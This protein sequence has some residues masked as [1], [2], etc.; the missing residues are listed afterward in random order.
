MLDAGAEIRRASRP[1]LP[2]IILLLCG[3]VALLSGAS[4]LLWVAAG[5]AAGY[6]LSGST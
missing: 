3:V 4:A 5:L 6:S 2:A 1:E